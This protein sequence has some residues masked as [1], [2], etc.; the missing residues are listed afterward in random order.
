[1]RTDR[2]LVRSSGGDTRLLDI[3]TLRF[4][5]E[6]EAPGLPTAEHF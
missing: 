4:A 5:G 2:P 6:P 1:M 3:E